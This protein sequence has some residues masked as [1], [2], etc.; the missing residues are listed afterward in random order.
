MDSLLVLETFKSSACNKVSATYYSWNNRVN[1]E[2]HFQ[3]KSS[4]R[5]VS[6]AGNMN[7]SPF[8]QKRS[9]AMPTQ[10]F[11][12]YTNMSEVQLVDT[13]Y[14]IKS[15]YPKAFLSRCLVASNNAKNHEME[16]L[17]MKM[18]CRNPVIQTKSNIDVK[19]LIVGQMLWGDYSFLQTDS[20]DTKNE[21]YNPAI[22]KD[23][24]IMM[25]KYLK[26]MIREFGHG[27]KS[28]LNNKSDSNKKPMASATFRHNRTSQNMKI[29]HNHET[30]FDVI[31][32]TKKNETMDQYYVIEKSISLSRLNLYLELIYPEESQQF[33]QLIPFPIATKNRR[34]ETKTIETHFKFKRGAYTRFKKL[35][36]DLKELKLL[37][38]MSK[39]EEYSKKPNLTI[40]NALE[41]I[42]MILAERNLAVQKL[43]TELHQSL[44]VIIMER[45]SEIL[46]NLPIRT[47]KILSIYFNRN[48]YVSKIFNEINKLE[49]STITQ[50]F[51]INIKQPECIKAASHNA[52]ILQATIYQLHQQKVNNI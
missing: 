6:Q 10:T 34:L 24:K 11:C 29:V 9:S 21:S 23:S 13:Q 39:S 36:E 14:A 25:K 46:I 16:K 26:M 1:K 12:H 3:P 49:N 19:G 52:L 30:S 44:Q 20:V 37:L 40:K 4:A 42:N 50:I 35:T 2:N 22:S 43:A 41:N 33:D 38:T 28:T 45:D 31:N 47:K 17:R 27:V 5:S 15:N 8:Q 51:K 18:L 7:I 48:D 32:Q